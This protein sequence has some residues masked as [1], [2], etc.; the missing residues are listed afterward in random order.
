MRLT[1][2]L[3]DG[4]IY[5]TSEKKGLFY[6]LEGDFYNYTGISSVPLERIDKLLCPVKPYKVVA[7]GLNYHLH[8]K[9][10]DSSSI[11]KEP[12]IFIKPDTSVIGPGENIIL[13]KRSSRVDYEAEL[14]FVISKDCKDI[15]E[16]EADEYILGYTCLNDVTAR[17]LQ[18]IDGQWTRAKGY[19]TFCPIGPSVVTG[20]EP[21]NLEIKAILNGEVKQQGN[22]SDM[23]FTVKQTLSYISG[24]MSLK[25]GDVIC[26]GTPSG[27]GPMSDGDTIEIYIEGIGSLINPVK[28]S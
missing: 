2:V 27:I 14:A 24:I 28:A 21:D 7:L 6:P 10:F 19:D 12:V 15:S 9:E 20:I 18:K 25:K 17:D 13:P 1:K 5:N 3:S 26:T 22:T 4:N 8:I 11:P 23:I 16:E